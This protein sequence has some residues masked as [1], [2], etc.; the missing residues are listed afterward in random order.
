MLPFK[1]I[2][3]RVNKKYINK[4]TILLIDNLLTKLDKG[5]SIYQFWKITDEKE[6]MLEIEFKNILKIKKQLSTD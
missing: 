2:Q 3:N 5:Y 4:K 6:Y 1:N